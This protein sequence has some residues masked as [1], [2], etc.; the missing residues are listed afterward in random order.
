MRNINDFYCVKCKKVK[1]NNNYKLTKLNNRKV[2]GGIMALK[3]ECVTCGTNMHKIIS[4]EKALKIKS[5]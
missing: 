2:K 4:K 5:Q 3:C 1:R